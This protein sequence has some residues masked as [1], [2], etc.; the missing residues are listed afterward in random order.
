MKLW[1]VLLFLFC[2]GAILTQP[3]FTSHYY[4]WM[5]EQNAYPPDADSIAIPIMANL[6]AWIVWGPAL[7]TGLFF[8]FRKLKP[9]FRIFVWDEEKKLKSWLISIGCL[10]P[11]A[12]LVYEAMRSVPWKNHVEIGYSIWWIS[13]WLLIRAALLTEKEPKPVSTGRGCSEPLTGKP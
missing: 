8:V 2:L 4:S 3:W 1:R 7:G 5:L 11:I 13:V 9:P 6:M 12:L 10:I